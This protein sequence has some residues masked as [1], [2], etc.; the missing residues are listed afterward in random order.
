MEI[1]KTSTM[2]YN[3][4]LLDITYKKKDPIEL[5]ST[6]PFILQFVEPINSFSFFQSLQT[7]YFVNLQRFIYH[8][9]SSCTWVNV[10]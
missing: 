7:V 3:T 2:F 1:E 5:A 8:I 9:H 6:G 10:L 4:F